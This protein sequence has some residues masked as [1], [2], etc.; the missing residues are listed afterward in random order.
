MS[1]LAAATSVDMR[2]RT[3]RRLTHTGSRGWDGSRQVKEDNFDNG[4]YDNSRVARPSQP[5][6]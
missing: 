4:E 5:I 3:E 6:R 1:S 2:T